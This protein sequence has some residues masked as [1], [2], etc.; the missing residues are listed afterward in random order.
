MQ[1]QNPNKF[2]Q[3]S[4]LILKISQ[5]FTASYGKAEKPELLKQSCTIIKSK[6][7]NKSKENFWRYQY[8]QF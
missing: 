6:N 1:F 4:N 8:L 3:N 7:K 5:Q 2:H